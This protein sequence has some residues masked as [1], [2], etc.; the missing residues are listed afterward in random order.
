[1][2]ERTSSQIWII[3]SWMEGG[4]EEAGRKRPP[5]KVGCWVSKQD[6]AF[7]YSSECEAVVCSVER[8]WAPVSP[9][10]MELVK[11]SR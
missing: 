5:K 1:M 6:M 11:L 9:Q 8:V 10:Q 3:C 2:W 4:K 7:V